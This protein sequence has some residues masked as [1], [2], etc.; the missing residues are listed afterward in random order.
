MYL[1]R[2]GYLV[3]KGRKFDEHSDAEPE[4]TLQNLDERSGG[5]T[6]DANQKY[7]FN[8]LRNKLRC[9]FVFFFQL[10]GNCWYLIRNRKITINKKKL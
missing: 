2:T 10:L 1:F 3:D 8:E 6:T 5:E 7:F 4:F 9:E